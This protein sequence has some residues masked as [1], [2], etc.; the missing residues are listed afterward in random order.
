M[1]AFQNEPFSETA[2]ASRPI[3]SRILRIALDFDE[4]VARGKEPQRALATMR[5][6]TGVYDP[7]ALAAF[8][9]SDLADEHFSVRTVTIATLREGM[10]L[11]EDVLSGQGGVLVSRGNRVS[12]GMLERLRN[13]A[14]VG[15]L[16]QSVR[17]RVPPPKVPATAGVD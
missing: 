16:Q 8:D 4:L 13:Y 10:I 3:G 5:Q 9:G 11:D 15:E 7:V 14:R 12:L 2:D 6:R 17:V 1:V